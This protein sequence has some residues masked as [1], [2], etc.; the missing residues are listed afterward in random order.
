MAQAETPSRPDM[1]IDID[2]TFGPEAHLTLALMRA[3]LAQ[4]AWGKPG[5]TLEL[6]ATRPLQG[7]ALANPALV[8]TAR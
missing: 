7:E 8:P 1:E 4:V 5:E 2:S 3:E 6:W